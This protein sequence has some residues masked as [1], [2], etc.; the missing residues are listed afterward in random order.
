ME[1][2][3]ANLRVDGG[4]ISTVNLGLSPCEENLIRQLLIED[5]RTN[6]SVR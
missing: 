6:E 4:I 3:G 5:S 2:H 1:V